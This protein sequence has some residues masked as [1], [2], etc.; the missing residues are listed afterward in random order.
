MQRGRASNDYAILFHRKRPIRSFGIRTITSGR[1]D[2]VLEKFARKE[3][4]RKGR[5]KEREADPSR[6]KENDKGLAYERVMD[7]GNLRDDKRTN[8]TPAPIEKK[9]SSLFSFLSISLSLTHSF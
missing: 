7:L 3:K 9:R 6:P 8:L 2:R 4:E 5:R 1:E